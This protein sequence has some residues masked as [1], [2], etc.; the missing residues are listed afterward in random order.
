[1]EGGAQGRDVARD[2]G[3]CSSAH[4]GEPKA[5]GALEGVSRGLMNSGLHVAKNNVAAGGGWA[6]TILGT[7]R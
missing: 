3:R 6:E 1:M 7:G 2:E 5:V 4:G